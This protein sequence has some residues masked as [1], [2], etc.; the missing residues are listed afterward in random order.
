MITNTVRHSDVYSRR[1]IAQLAIAGLAGPVLG[2][3]GDAPGG[4]R[5]AVNATSFRGLPPKPGGDAIDAVIQALTECGV[6]DCEL[7]ASLLEPSYGAQPDG[8]HMTMAAMTPQMMRRELRKWRLRTPAAYFEAIGR[9]FEKA[10]IAVTAYSYS[11]DST[12]TVEEIERGFVVAKA[13]G[14]D[15]VTADMSLAIAQRV[16]PVADGH[17]MV[18][19]LTGDCAPDAGTALP[20]PARLAAALKLSRYFKVNLDVG[21]FAAD[22]CDPVA[23]L[24]DRHTEIAS[25]HLKDCRGRDKEAVQWGQGQTPIREVLQLL[26]R[27]GWPIRAYV[28]YAYAG[29]G[30]PV[31]EV[32]RC[33]AYAKAA[34]A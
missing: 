24:R 25:I 29:T 16:A 10:G 20:R 9:R 11:P 23:F 18:V 12:F 7:A 34:L 1:G 32:K 17:R 31:E 28:D 6:R 26:K 21:R 22:D 8:H 33:F 14:A 15:V 4:V 30:T 19:A 3:F 2:A 13:L 27:E 5:L